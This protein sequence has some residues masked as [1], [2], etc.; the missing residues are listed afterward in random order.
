[1]YLR[2]FK[3]DYMIDVNFIF[4]T[5]VKESQ[6]SDAKS[7][8]LKGYHKILWSKSLPNWKIFNLN[9]DNPELSKNYLY[10]KSELGYFVFGSDAI[11]HIRS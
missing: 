7:R 10:H 2:L 5:E 1:M 9:D 8:T 3:T 6:D 11:T 4:F